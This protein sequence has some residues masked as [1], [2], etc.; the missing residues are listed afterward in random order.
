MNEYSKAIIKH[1]PFEDSFLAQQTTL[2]L[3]T[4]SGQ[5]DECLARGIDLLRRLGID[6]AED[7]T[8]EIIMN[9]VVSANIM[10]SQFDAEQILRLCETSL[11]EYSI[12]ISSIYDGIHGAM[13]ANSSPFLPLITSEIVKYSLQYGISEESTIAFQFFAAMKITFEWDYVAGQ[14]WSG[15]VK[16]IIKKHD[17]IN[18]QSKKKS[19]THFSSRISS[20]WNI[21]IWFHCPIEISYLLMKIHQEAM[22]VG[23]VDFVL[24]AFD[25]AGRYKFMGGEN[26]NAALKTVGD[27][28]QLVVSQ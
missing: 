15:I 10:A 22:K 18:K 19:F 2:R 8:G 4:Q 21:D 5:L 3:L 12:F 16:Q 24:Y 1:A 17:A 28:I 27:R 9:S 20:L 6:I 23:E 13:I 14:Y 25:F 11:D 7:P 26:L